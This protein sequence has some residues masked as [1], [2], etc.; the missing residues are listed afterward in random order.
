MIWHFQPLLIRNQIALVYILSTIKDRGRHRLFPI[1]PTHLNL[2]NKRSAV[3]E[4]NGRWE[5]A[6]GRAKKEG[7]SIKLLLTYK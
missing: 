4:R 1:L 2:G 7:Q 5:K 6:M 3:I